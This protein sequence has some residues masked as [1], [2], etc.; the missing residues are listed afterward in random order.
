MNKLRTR[1]KICGITRIQDALT[2]ARFGVDAIGL[3]FYQQS[4]RYINF[5]QAAKIIQQLPPFIH[6]VGLFV[7][8]DQSY[9]EQAIS[10]TKIDILQFHGNE[11]EQDCV[12]Y[13]LPYIKAIRVKNDINISMIE[14]QYDSAS[15][16]LLDSYDQDF[17]GGTG[18]TFD[19]NGVSKC[20]EKPIILAGGL[21]E[22][23]VA[24]AIRQVAPYAVDVSSGVE[25]KKGIKDKIKINNFMN[26]V[27]YV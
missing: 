5:E 22:S 7:D 2:V 13:S 20:R 26:E 14:E 10:Q 19:W 16:L 4:P 8:A 18:H 6:T 3:V 23:N 9:I 24:R 12:I 25:Q 17:F 11:S 27:N 1:V 15:A 21:N